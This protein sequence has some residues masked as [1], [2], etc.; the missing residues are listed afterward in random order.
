MRLAAAG[1]LPKPIS[2]PANVKIRV[3]DSAD[4]DGLIAF[5]AERDYVAD[6]V[7]PNTIEV[8]R[9]SSVRHDHVRV[10]LELYL[11][12]WH[13]SHPEAAAEFIENG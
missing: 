2:R 9:P 6:P 12:A 13:A 7:A 11:A 10:E 8:S 4:L 1:E 5:L 3:Q